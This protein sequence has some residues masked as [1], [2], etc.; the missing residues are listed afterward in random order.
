MW[1]RG[2]ILRIKNKKLLGIILSVMLSLSFTSIPARA[3]EDTAEAEPESEP[4]G[5]SDGE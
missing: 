2:C 1:K 3:E 5:E 4:D